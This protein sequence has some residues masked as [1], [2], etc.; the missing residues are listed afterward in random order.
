MNDDEAYTK[1]MQEVKDYLHKVG[2]I[3]GEGRR[4][5]GNDPLADR[6]SQLAEDQRQARAMGVPYQADPRLAQVPTFNTHLPTNQESAYTQWKAQ[7]APRD[8]GQDYDLR[9]AFKAGLKPDTTGHWPDTFKKPGHPTFSDESKYARF[10][11]PGHWQGD[12]YTPG[13]PQSTTGQSPQYGFSPQQPNAQ[14]MR[15]GSQEAQEALRK[16]NEAWANIVKRRGEQGALVKE[17]PNGL[18]YHMGQATKKMPKEVADIVEK[19][20]TS[21]PTFAPKD[22]QFIN[23]AL[24]SMGFTVIEGS[25]K[26]EVYVAYGGHQLPRV[27]NTMA[28]EGY[29]QGALANGAPYEHKPSWGSRGPAGLEDRMLKLQPREESAPYW[30]AHATS[31]VN[32][33]LANLKG[34]EGG[35]PKGTALGDTPV[36][37]ALFSPSRGWGDS[38]AQERKDYYYNNI[39]YPHGGLW[40]GQQDKNIPSQATQYKENVINYLMKGW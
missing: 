15:D 30:G 32:E 34:Y 12:T 21:Y 23:K 20:N 26:G 10:G 4:V 9:G 33:L 31:S 24:T 5:A 7:Y 40:E 11:N 19:S 37:Q 2:T 39:S 35:L 17:Y 1:Y 22:P 25:R 36:G 28:H 16:M 38:P 3:P 27:A 14:H 13:T 8:S 6:F 29:H 18:G